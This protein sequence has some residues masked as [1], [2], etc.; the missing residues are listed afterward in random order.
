[1]TLSFSMY[2]HKS[3]L[4]KI[5]RIGY[6]F[7]IVERR[8]YIM[9]NNGPNQFFD[10]M[11]RMATGAVS[12]FQGFRQHIQGEVK[13]HINQ[14]LAEMDFVPREDF[15]IVEAMAKKARSDHDKLLKRVEALEAKVGIKQSDA[16][17]PKA[18]VKTKAK[19]KVSKPAAKKT[20]ASK[21][22]AAP[23]P[24]TKKR[25]ASTKKD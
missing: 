25:V 19:A 14:F 2:E 13:S 1:M 10:D 16:K 22:K 23:K 9:Q 21:S 8:E 24:K 3:F 17:A 18:K 7:A 20:S 11:A 15:E 6:A 12:A 4:V 5:I